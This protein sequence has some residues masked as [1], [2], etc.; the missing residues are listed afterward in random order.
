MLLRGV[1]RASTAAPTYFE[2]EKLEVGE[3]QIGVFVDGGV[4]MA[5]NSALQLFLI[6]TLKG[7]AQ[8]FRLS[9]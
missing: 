6:A 4:S 7:L 8:I 2:V 1:I 9:E 5:N 3:G